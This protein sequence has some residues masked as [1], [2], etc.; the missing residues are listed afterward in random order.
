M[1]TTK[2]NLI[3]SILDWGMGMTNIDLHNQP[4]T[5]PSKGLTVPS[6]WPGKTQ[7]NLVPPKKISL[8]LD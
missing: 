7:N 1:F 4:H 2:G 3:D 8:L 5:A 6:K